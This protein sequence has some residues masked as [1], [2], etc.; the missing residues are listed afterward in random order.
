MSQYASQNTY[1]RA[2]TQKKE[3]VAST[4][5]AA[6][7]VQAFRQN[8]AAMAGIRADTMTLQTVGIGQQ[9]I[10][11]HAEEDE[12]LQMKPV[13]QRQTEEDETLQGKFTPLQQKSNATGLP[14]NVKSGVES[15]SGL[16]LNDVRVH[17]NSSKPAQ[18]QAHAYTQGT[19]IHV[20]SGQEKH[21]PHE[22]WHVVQQKQGRVQPTMQM[23]GVSVNNDAGLEHEADVM[24]GKVLQK[25]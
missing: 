7:V 15:L 18:I 8:M 9:T 21:V 6:K 4:S 11:R 14:D 23:Q 1:D 17:Y 19:D 5:S 16:S 12:T 10:Q 20:A 13:I 25:T 2:P 3:V 24:G 22:A